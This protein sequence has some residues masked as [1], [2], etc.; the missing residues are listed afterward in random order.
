M[1]WFRVGGMAGGCIRCIGC[2]G[3]E[4]GEVNCTFL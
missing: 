1:D 2:F 4:S 3:G